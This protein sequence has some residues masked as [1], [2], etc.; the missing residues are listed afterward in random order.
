MP[1]EEEST[2]PTSTLTTNSTSIGNTRNQPKNRLP[3]I[4]S[5][6]SDTANSDKTIDLTTKNSKSKSTSNSST[7]ANQSNRGVINRKTGKV[8][9]RGQRGKYLRNNNLNLNPQIRSCPPRT[10]RQVENSA[11]TGVSLQ[12]SEKVTILRIPLSGS[13]TISLALCVILL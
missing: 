2:L 13:R 3:V 5:V 1:I 10:L 4:I 12:F 7:T 9:H 6:D 11:T 8:R